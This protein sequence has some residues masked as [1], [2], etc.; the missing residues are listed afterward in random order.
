MH[1]LDAIGGYFEMDPGRGAGEPLSGAL[2]NSGRNALR[3]IVRSLGV[4]K[5][6]VP[7]YICPVVIDALKAEGCA[8]V[9][10]SL[11]DSMMP[12]KTFPDREHVLYVNYFGVCGKKVDALAVKCGNLIVDCA[13]AYFS[14]AKGLASFYSPRKF[15]GVPDGG[16]AFGVESAKYA[17]DSSESRIG[18]LVERRDFG[19]TAAGYEMFR[20]AENSLDG[21]EVR[22]MSNLTRNILSRVDLALARKKRLDNFMYLSARLQTDFP[23]DLSEDDVPMVYPYVARHPDVRKAL[24]AERIYVATYWPGVKTGNRMLDRLVPL[25][26]DQRYGLEEMK[27]IVQAVMLAERRAA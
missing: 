13:Q 10:Y 8:I 15:F 18:H 14:E 23:M 17:R 9:R 19:A 22:T 12:D 11:D 25:P 6:H 20:N 16:V 1:E 27:R 2:L 4:S 7:D 3:H 21:A 26:V 24:I 5:M